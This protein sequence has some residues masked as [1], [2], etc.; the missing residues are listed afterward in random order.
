M[1]SEV[2]DDHDKLWRFYIVLQQVFYDFWVQSIRYFTE[3]NLE[4]ISKALTTG[5]QRS[6]TMSACNQDG[7]HI[8]NEGWKN[9]LWIITI[10]LIILVFF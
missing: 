7:W 2:E 6:T 5:E 1:F 8:R 10:I 4:M 9:L 3:E